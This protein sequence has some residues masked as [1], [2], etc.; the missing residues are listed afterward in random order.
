[1]GRHR[2]QPVWPTSSTT[3][4]VHRVRIETPGPEGRHPVGRLD[5]RVLAVPTRAQAAKA[6]GAAG[7][8]VEQDLLGALVLDDPEPEQLPATDL[9]LPDGEPHPA[10]A[11]AVEPRPV[12]L[13]HAGEVAYL[14]RRRDGSEAAIQ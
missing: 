6:N 9:D 13:E 1:M 14:V 3:A 12:P 4:C 5:E 10:R 7:L 8:R 11:A 2:C